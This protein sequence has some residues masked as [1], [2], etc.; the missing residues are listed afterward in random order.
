M[1]NIHSSQNTLQTEYMILM[2]SWQAACQGWN[3]R[4]QKN[5]EKSYIETFSQIVPQG[6]QAMERLGHVIE[7]ARREVK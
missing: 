6:I 3:D 7:Q 2:Q 1:N 5:F 4:N